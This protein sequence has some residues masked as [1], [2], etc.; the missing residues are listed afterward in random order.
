MKRLDVDPAIEQEVL[1]VPK[2]NRQ[3][4][5][6]KSRKE[7]TKSL[8]LRRM[9]RRCTQSSSRPL[10]RRLG[11]HFRSAWKRS[12]GTCGRRYQDFIIPLRG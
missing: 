7:A 1:P 12:I 8:S 11:G 3:F 5:G 2:N 9:S 10:H 6:A 4:I